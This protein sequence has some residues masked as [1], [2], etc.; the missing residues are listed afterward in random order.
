MATMEKGWSS[1]LDATLMLERDLRAGMAAAAVM[2]EKRLVF[3][4][5]LVLCQTYREMLEP[6]RTEPGEGCDWQ[7]F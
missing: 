7:H 2:S 1:E 5:M 6:G 3:A 4:E